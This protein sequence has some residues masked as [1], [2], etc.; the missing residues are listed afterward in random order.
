MITRK[1]IVYTANS[2]NDLLHLK[3]FKICNNVIKKAN[4]SA[5]KEKE[6]IEFAE[7]V[8]DFKDYLKQYLN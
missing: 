8:E 1:D 6:L 4:K 7:T 3:R 2:L 5:D